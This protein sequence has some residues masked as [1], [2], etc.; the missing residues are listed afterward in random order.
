M[1]E[2]EQNVKVEVAE[3]EKNET[4]NGNS[5]PALDEKILQQVEVS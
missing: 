3:G 5:I 2:V 4:E 1:T